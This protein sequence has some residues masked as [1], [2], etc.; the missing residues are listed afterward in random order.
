MNRLIVLTTVL[1][2]H[3][4]FGHILQITTD[5]AVGGRTYAVEASGTVPAP[6]AD[7]L[8]LM[9]NWP[10][11]VG[12][13]PMY[14]PVGVTLADLNGDDTMV[15]I[16][17]GTDNILHVWNYHGSELAGWPQTLS[18]AIQSKVA[19]GDIYADGRMFLVCATRDGN[20]HVRKTD[21]GSLAGWPRNAGGNGGL[22]SPT[23]FDIDGND[24]LE[25]IAV[26]YPPGTVYV[27]RHDGTVYT[28]WPKTTD[29]L[30]VATA[31]VGDVDADG[32]V[33]ICV[34][35]YRSLYLWDKNGN[36]EPGW[37]INLGDGASYA[38]PALYDIDNDG[39]LEIA[40]AC[41]PNLGNGR[42]YLF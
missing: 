31:S 19:V 28:G 1:I 8:Q 32:V 15:I 13:G 14:R 34:P 41:Y 4:T 36:L 23:L 27:W 10:Q 2:C 38:Q 6:A 29:Y 20:V 25:I 39:R 35:S 9:P 37:P 16:A 22:V 26:Q 33:E 12:V 3:A 30:A 5:A 42:V 7:G 11:H 21:G 18:G 17:G 40:H 24:T